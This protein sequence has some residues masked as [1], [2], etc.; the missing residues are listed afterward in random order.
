MTQPPP[1]GLAAA[2]RQR[3]E[4]TRQRAIVA[5]RQLDRD[6]TPITY[7]SLAT[8]AGVSRSWLYRQ[9]D[10]RAEIDRLRTRPTSPAVPAAQRASNPS[11]AQRISDLI[12]TN[13]AHHEQNRKLQDQI[14]VLLGH[15]RATT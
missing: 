12:D 10:L 7:S 6:G 11:Q 3:T 13:R 15:Q 14:A 5:L 1:S 4:Y 8:T 9:P 2:A